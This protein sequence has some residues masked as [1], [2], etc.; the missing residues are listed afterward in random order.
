MN[1]FKLILIALAAAVAAGCSPRRAA[2]ESDDSANFAPQTGSNTISDIGSDELSADDMRGNTST[3]HKVGDW[4]TNNTIPENAILCTV[5]FGYDKYVVAAGERAKLDAIAQKA[6]SAE[7][8]VV[9]YSD[10]Y[11]S[12]EYNLA[13]SDKRAQAVKKY[14]NNIGSANSAQTKAMGEQFA[15]QGGTKEEVREDRKVIVVDGNAK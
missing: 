15:R 4:I 10:Y 5:Y 9:G 11:G 14:L 12:D 8:Y 3:D 13:L 6:N 1:A 2:P 7:I